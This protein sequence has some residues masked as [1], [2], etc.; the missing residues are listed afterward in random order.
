MLLLDNPKG[1]RKLIEEDFLHWPQERLEQ[2][3]A[4]FAKEF[5]TKI[6]LVDPW[7][8]LTYE[9]LDHAI[10]NLAVT[11]HQNGIQKNSVVMIQLPNVAESMIV[12]H[13]A[14]RAGAIVLPVT[15]IYREAEIKTILEQ[16]Q[17]D[18]IFIPQYF[19]NND[20]VKMLENIQQLNNVPKV[21]VKIPN[22]RDTEGTSFIEWSDYI[23]NPNAE[24]L[25]ERAYDPEEYSLLMFTSG[26]TSSP[27]G[28]LH[29]HGTLGV[30]IST[31]D[32]IETTGFNSVFLVPSP[33][34]HI[35]GLVVGI[36]GPMKLGATTVFM[37]IWDAKKCLQIIEDEKCSYVMAA[38][39][40][41]SQL[42]DEVEAQGKGME[43]MRYFACGGADVSEYL[44]RRA[45][46][47]LPHCTFSRIY[48]S[49]EAPGISKFK[50]NYD[51]NKRFT[52]DGR[53]TS[54]GK[55]KIKE[56]SYLPNG[57]G[58][59]MVYGPQ[60]FIRYI[61]WVETEKAMTEEWFSTGDLALFDEDGFIQI[62][63]RE[64]DIIIRG[65]ENYS[66]KEIED[67]LIAHP[68]V[69]DIGI[70]GYKDE[71]MGERGCAFVVL[72]QRNDTIT[73]S[74][75]TKLLAEK[76]VAKQKWPER[77]EVVDALPYTHSG[78]LQKFILRDMLNNEVALGK[79]IN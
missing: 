14:L 70:V 67:I 1:R 52:H 62:T 33:V 31:F 46:S 59:L 19:K 24:R 58:E 9:E 37:P 49:T 47:I 56:G 8:R 39:P 72:N 25:E 38:T 75:L 2:R 36:L 41:L 69:K 40:F 61:S 65:G 34:T 10:N 18:V 60:L 50:Q 29:T 12:F 7:N 5:P 32:G 51:E 26:T 66:A 53:P 78:K 13:A 77:L 16:V 27:K 28:V 17:P 43:T 3:L 74:D 76:K 23:K 4:K 73:L 22:E 55:A 44:L 48:G 20:Y 79:L 57:S 21:A 68:K 63:G 11:F 71:V 45:K 64:K 15:P 35:T 42:I 54:P 6:A 30:A